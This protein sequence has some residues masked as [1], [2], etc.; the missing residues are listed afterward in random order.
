M[1]YLWYSEDLMEQEKKTKK[2]G[3][4][5]GAERRNSE[6][7]A[8]LATPHVH[9]IRIADAEARKRAITVLGEVRQP[10]CGFTDYRFLVTN[11]HLKVLRTMAIPL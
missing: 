1:T 5:R 3:V 7:E 2:K 8:T 10:Y 11:E 4:P 6:V 9:L